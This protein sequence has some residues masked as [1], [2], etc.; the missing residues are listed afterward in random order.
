M[1][2]VAQVL[3]IPDKSDLVQDGCD[4]GE[5]AESEEDGDHSFF[6]QQTQPKFFRVDSPDL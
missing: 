3:Q 2:P 1:P 6:A 4:D 5:R